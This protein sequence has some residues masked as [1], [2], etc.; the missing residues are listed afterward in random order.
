ML[1][2]PGQKVGEPSMVLWPEA[3]DGG[4]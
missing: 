1:V 4:A 2:K 3:E